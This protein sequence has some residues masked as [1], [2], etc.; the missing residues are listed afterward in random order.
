MRY[1]VSA[2]FLGIRLPEMAASLP[3]PHYSRLFF[4]FPAYAFVRGRF[5]RTLGVR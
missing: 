3:I 2:L 1:D 5:C 4:P